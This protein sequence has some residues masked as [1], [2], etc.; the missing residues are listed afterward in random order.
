MT[1]FSIV[2]L[3]LFSLLGFAVSLAVDRCSASRWSCAAWSAAPR[4]RSRA[5]S[6][7]SRIAVLP[8]RRHAVRPRTARR[9]RRPHL[10]GGAAPAALPRSRAVLERPPR[11]SAVTRAV[12]FAYHDVGVR[13]LRV[14]LEQGVWC[15]WSSRTRMHPDEHD[16]VRQRRR[17]T[18]AGT[19]SRSPRPPTR[20]R[21]SSSRACA[22]R[23]P[24]FLFS[25]YYR[26]LLG[27]ELLAVARARRL[28]HARLAAA[29]VPRPRAGQLGGAA[30]R[31]RDRRHAARDDRRAPT[32]ATSSTQQ[33]VPILR[34]RHRA[35][36]Y[37]ARSA[38]PPSSRSTRALPAL[39]AG[40]ARL[41]P[42]DLPGGQLLRPPHAA[43]T[44]RSTGAPERPPC[45]IWCARWRR[46]TPAPS[47]A[48]A[49]CRCG[50]CGRCRRRGRAPRARNCAGS[51][52]RC[53]RCAPTATL[54]LLEFELDGR[55]CDAAGFH[56]RFGTAALPLENGTGPKEAT[57]HGDQSTDPRRQRLHRPPPVGAHPARTPTGA[58]SAWTWAPSASSR[59]CRTRA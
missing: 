2:P 56:A 24:D 20:T 18:R 41:R 30:R 47:R 5:C 37:C 48:R 16:L 23:A 40:T 46:R 15:R 17:A 32:P 35:A 54:R 45:T 26:Q 59:C 50:C 31:A 10:R 4:R 34:R 49:G 8:D 28:Q 13:C 19:G 3:Q 22:P 12:V 36:R 52:A 43:P 58:C 25:F 51:T 7:C 53:G 42:Q 44:A 6:R 27:A 1:G 9:V 57:N 21:R 11:T 38:S 14:L 33:A 55:P 29:E 39:L